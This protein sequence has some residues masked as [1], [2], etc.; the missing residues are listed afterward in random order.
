MLEGGTQLREGGGL[1]LAVLTDLAEGWEREGS[2]CRPP[3]GAGVA[4]ETVI[5]PRHNPAVGLVRVGNML[6]FLPKCNKACFRLRG[7]YCSATR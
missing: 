4:A 5:Y 6:V 2:R 1:L 3:P 7:C